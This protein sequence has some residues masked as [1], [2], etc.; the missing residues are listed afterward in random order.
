MVCAPEHSHLTQNVP[1]APLVRVEGAGVR[2]GPHQALRAIDLS[3]SEGDRLAVIGP[4]GAGKTTLLRLLLGLES[5]SEGRILWAEPSPRIGYV[6]QRLGFDQHFP[7]TVEEFLAVNHPGAGIWLGGVPRRVSKDISEVLLRTGGNDV[8][9]QLL[10]TLSGGQLQ[11]VLV[12]AALLQQPKV[13]ILDEPSASI[14][15]RGA[16]E[17]R[18]LLFALHEAE[19]LTLVFVSHDLH[20]VGELASR[21]ACL[22]GTLCGL[23]APAEILSSHVLGAVYGRAIHHL[24]TCNAGG[25]S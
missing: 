20:F 6:P 14:D 24:H 25:K 13:L 7:L 12:A 21:V 11:R 18:A 16:D 10:G 22:N 3:I 8:G 23:G 2:Y 17:L 15:H 4:N 19:R 1:S 5:P 9:R